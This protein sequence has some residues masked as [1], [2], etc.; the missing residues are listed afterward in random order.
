M[1]QPCNAV[2]ALRDGRHVI[3]CRELE[4]TSEL[5]LRFGFGKASQRDC[6]ES[7]VHLRSLAMSFTDV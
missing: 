6:D 5:N 4:T 7:K 2:G 1:E 3:I